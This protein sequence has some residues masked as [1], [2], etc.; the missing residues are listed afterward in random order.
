M[1]SAI[2]R[3]AAVLAV[4]LAPVAGADV[5]VA[6]LVGA[7]VADPACGG[8]TSRVALQVVEKDGKAEAR[9]SIPA[10]AVYDVP[11]GEVVIDGDT[12]DTKGLSQPLVWNPATQTLSGVLTKEAVPVYRI[13]VEFR[14]GEP[15]AKPPAREWR[16]GAP[17]VVWSV[18]TG[19]APVW[20][21]IERDPES[22]RLFV[23]N[24]NGI[25]TAVGRD[26]KIRWRFETGKAIRGQ[27]KV[28]GGALFVAS[29][30]GFLHKL[31]RDDGAEIWRARV[32][33]GAPA[34]IPPNEKDTRWDRYGSSVVADRRAIYY[35]S[36]D[37]NLYALDSRT[38]REI[39]RAAAGDLMTAT[40]AL[41][42][43]SVIFAAFD[44][45]VR[46]VSARDG[47]P[48]WTYDAKLAVPGDLVVA[49]DRVLVG[50][51]SY[52]LIA[53]DARSGAELWK[54]YYW[55]SW[56]ES[57]PVV[58]DG[59]AYT[60]SSDATKVYAVDV[61][62]GAFRW[63]TD[64]PGWSWQRTAV[65]EHLVIAGTAGAGEYPGRRAGSLVA[66]DRAT[67]EV[68]WIHVEP[69]SKETLEAKQGWGFGAS[70]VVGDGVVYAADLAGRLSAFALR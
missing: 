50:S 67:G 31:D 40:P 60:G 54:R 55:F 65:T 9:M 52:D 37:G 34:R 19:G 14:R 59:V 27:P 68:R 56:I 20:A 45:K 63:K 18:D 42:G 51:R 28:S 29:D 39:W 24:E 30:S 64:V 23:G 36:R 46:A 13:P 70:P 49:G 17:T 4:A 11:L 62:T 7:W 3:C 10:I 6:D 57:P 8:E 26:G 1:I 25:V 61:A 53:L 21:G 35:A 41:H 44:G 47:K 22:G 16:A 33:A 66:L 12:I 43:D 15:V 58:R 69:P 38:G 5:K 32:D 48:R 2:R